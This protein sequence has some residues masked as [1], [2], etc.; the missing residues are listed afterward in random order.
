MEYR[1]SQSGWLQSGEE[2]ATPYYGGMVSENITIYTWKSV[3]EPNSEAIIGDYDLRLRIMDLDG[4]YSEYAYYNNS[5]EVLNNIPYVTSFE[6]T[7]RVPEEE[8]PPY[9]LVS[10]DGT[11]FDDNGL[12]SC[13]WR[14][15]NNTF[16]EPIT[17]LSLQELRYG[18]V[19]TDVANIT[20]GD[21]HFF[22]RVLDTDGDWSKWFS[23]D[24]FYVDDGDGY[25][26]TSDAFPEDSTQWSDLDYDGWGDNPSGNRPDAFPKDPLEWKDT[27]GDGSGDNSDIAVNIPNIYLQVS[28]GIVLVVSGVIVMEVFS[29]RSRESISE[30]LEKLIEQGIDNERISGAFN[31]LENV[32]GAHFMSS[33]ISD[34]KSILSEYHTKQ[35]NILTIMEELHDLRMDS[36]AFEQEGGNAAELVEQLSELEAELI[37]E[38]ESDA[39]VGYLND[40]QTKFVEGLSKKGDK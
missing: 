13:Q 15:S 22:V 8:Y 3:F 7:S 33:E 34:A 21:Y 4:N 20:V 5:I 24:L 2:L 14:Y 26:A 38:S 1:S 35:K 28:G 9:V 25:D 36:V 11:A 16:D 18:C 39:T 6:V 19:I 37:S 23:S 29:R 30:Q 40:L 17:T 27:D 31:N 10:L 32:E 12:T